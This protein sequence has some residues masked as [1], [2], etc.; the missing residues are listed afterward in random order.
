MAKTDDWK[1]GING[2]G[3]TVQYGTAYN[4]M[5]TILNL[6]NV[7]DKNVTFNW[8]DLGLYG[9][10]G[11]AVYGGNLTLTDFQSAGDGRYFG[12]HDIQRRQAQ[13]NRNR[14]ELQP[15]LCVEAIRLVGQAQCK[16]RRYI[17]IR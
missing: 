3:A 5:L 4:P 7:S 9:A 11:L 2:S 14:H 16:R 15:R 8:E 1:T 12:R 17:C 10:G 13:H 6:E